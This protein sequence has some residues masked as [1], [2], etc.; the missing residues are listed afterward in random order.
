MKRSSK[1][2]LDVTLIDQEGLIYAPHKHRTERSA[3][4]GARDHGHWISHDEMAA[5]A[6]ELGA[7]EY[8]AKPYELLALRAAIAAASASKRGR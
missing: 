5:R 8:L 7:F 2:R 6:R 1:A 3:A 4:G